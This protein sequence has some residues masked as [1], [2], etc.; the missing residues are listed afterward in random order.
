MLVGWL[1]PEEWTAVRLSLLVATV[2]VVASLPVALAVAYLLARGRFW[3]RSLL[4][5]LVHFLSSCRRSSRATY[6]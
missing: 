1:S 2:S 5:T 3:G 4:D 6:S